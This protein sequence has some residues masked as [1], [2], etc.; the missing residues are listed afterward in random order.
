MP[1]SNN[2]GE[3]LKKIRGI[4]EWFED[5]DE[6]DVEKGLEKVKEGAKL[7]K[8]SRARLEELENEFEI[9]KKDLE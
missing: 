9:V 4:V 2:L 3:T 8:E 7:I 6:V 1:I 5:Q